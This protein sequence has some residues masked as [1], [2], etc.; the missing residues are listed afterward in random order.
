MTSPEVAE[1]AQVRHR[2]S[3]ACHD[4]AAQHHAEAAR[5]FKGA[6]QSMGVGDF[7]GTEHH[8]NLAQSHAVLATEQHK[9]LDHDHPATYPD[10]EYGDLRAALGLT[11]S[12]TPAWQRLLDSEHAWAALHLDS[13]VDEMTKGVL[14]RDEIHLAHLQADVTHMKARVSAVKGLYAIFTPAQKRLFDD[15]HA[16]MPVGRR[17]IRHRALHIGS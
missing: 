14:E 13:P 6:A 9:L 5:H 17:G 4:Q 2:Y 7:V 15:F 10:R 12:Q 3:A 11:P 1:A 16:V 8:A